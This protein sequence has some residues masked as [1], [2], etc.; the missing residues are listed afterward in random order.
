M[1]TLR[2]LTKGKTTIMIAHRLATVENADRILVLDDGQIVQEGTHGQLVAETG[3]Y[4]YLYNAQTD[5][6]KKAG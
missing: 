1:E 5:G 2:E 6:K 4:R 3:P